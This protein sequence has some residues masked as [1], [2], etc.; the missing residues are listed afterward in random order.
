M[1]PLPTER[2]CTVPGWAAGGDGE[3]KSLRLC[4]PLS[5]HVTLNKS[6]VLSEPPVLN[7]H[8]ESLPPLTR[9][10]CGSRKTKCPPRLED[11]LTQEGEKRPR[12]AGAPGPCAGEAAPR[13]PQGPDV[14]TLFAHSWPSYPSV[15]SPISTTLHRAQLRGSFPVDVVNCDGYFN[16]LYFRFHCN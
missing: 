8:G 14:E 1:R 10:P 16:P 11:L 9:G 3:M 15:L 12:A 4:V 2:G 5:S 13:A 6:R 7:L